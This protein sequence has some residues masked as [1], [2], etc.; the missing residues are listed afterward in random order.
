MGVPL[1]GAMWCYDQLPSTLTSHPIIGVTFR[2]GSTIIR[3]TS[4]S[5]SQSP[6]LPILGNPAFPPG[7]D[8]SQYKTLLSSGRDCAMYFLE[9]THWPSIEA[10]TSPTGQFQ[11]PFWKA[12]RLHHFLF[13]I[14]NPAQFDRVLTIFEEYCRDTGDISQVL[15][16]TY[17]L[18]NTPQQQPDLIFLQKCEMDLQRCFTNTQKQNIIRF[19]LKSSICTK[20]QETNYKILTSWYYTPQLLHQYFPTLQ[21]DA[22]DARQKRG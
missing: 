8:H 12:I 9:G 18:L 10:L 11:L 2:I 13:S 22:G 19:S 14:A 17:S 16:K 15:S 4:L 20:I 1:K 21:T 3:T 5:S 6:L 7:L